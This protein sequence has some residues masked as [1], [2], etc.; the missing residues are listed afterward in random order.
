MTLNPPATIRTV[1]AGA[2]VG[3]LL[4]LSLG[5][6]GLAQSRYSTSE[7]QELLDKGIKIEKT[8]ES[9]NDLEL[10]EEA[11]ESYA[12]ALD[13]DPT[14]TKASVRLGYVLYVLKRHKDA[15]AMLR[16]AL[17]HSNGDLEVEHTLGINLYQLG[18]EDEAV[19]HL[20]KVIDGGVEL[21]EA[22]FILGK[23]AIERGDMET[24]DAHF[25]KYRELNPS[26]PQGNR[27]LAS[28]HIKVGAYDEALDDLNR[29]IALEPDDIN[30][31]ISRAA[32]HFEEQRYD[33]AIESY[34]Y[35]LKLNPTSLKIRYD[36]ASVH[37]IA[38]DYDKAQRE[39]EIIL[40]ADPE[41][42][43]A[44]Y[45]RSSALLAKG[46]TAAAKEGFL[47]LLE[48]KEDYEF[49][50]LKLAQVAL[51]E[52]D[53]GGVV[54]WLD[55]ASSS[56]STN[57]DVLALAGELHRKLG[58]T[59][60]AIENHNTLIQLD[61]ERAEYRMMLGLDY[62]AAKDFEGGVLEFRTAAERDPA[63]LGA[64]K[65]LSAAMLYDASAL[66]SEGKY[67][68]AVKVLEQALELDF[69][70]VET[71]VNLAIMALAVDD[72]E[73]ATDYL[74]DV[75]ALDSESPAVRRL[76]ARLM[77]HRER[78]EE[79]ATTLE[80]LAQEAPEQMTGAS[81]HDL[82]VAQGNQE[83]W[84]RAHEAIAKAKEL[85]IESPRNRS[86]IAARLAL[87]FAK[88]EQWRKAEDLFDE[89]LQDVDSLSSVERVRLEYGIAIIALRNEKFGRAERYLES[90]QSGYQ[91][92]SKKERKAVTSAKKLDLNLELAYAYYRG[93]KPA[94]ALELLDEK[95][96]G[97][98]DEAA[99]VRAIREKLAISAYDEGDYAT[100]IALLEKAAKL[101]ETPDVLLN[102][103]AA[104]YQ[105]GQQGKAAKIFER[106]AAKGVVQ[107]LHNYAIYLDNVANQPE[108]A[109]KYYQDYVAKGGPQKTEVEKII[110]MKRRVFGLQGGG[111][112]I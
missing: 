39:F 65:G 97:E 5:G 11:A 9:S 37:Y 111:D 88:K 60:Q 63:N 99:L 71:R 81:W 28:I 35:A 110:E 103:A 96:K 56:S 7:A 54:K 48:L 106:F 16:K 53:L 50:R 68:E 87:S 69:H 101:D 45:F 66:S 89:A 92:L 80:A 93:G 27:A 25:S 84:E 1:L 29:V 75:K 58:N 4:V 72:V 62:I 8:A 2:F 79:A 42:F 24:A 73:R 22:Y 31:Y 57:P 6:I 26:D 30:A 108:E 46:D 112:D 49:G 38:K 67:D 52:G 21:P 13:A 33:E 86:L 10:Y 14:L 90:V 55:D 43:A 23:Y 40:E 85:G 3:T 91:Q 98:G 74:S 34:L 59:T 83:N 15:V 102:L 12:D 19:A 105:S 100:T 82:A 41:H 109:L 64:W 107:A 70:P 61:P 47:K 20:Q 76:D 32:V 51:I 94:K 95:Q 44:L 78:Y 17:D 18:Q 77:V 104:Q 36:L